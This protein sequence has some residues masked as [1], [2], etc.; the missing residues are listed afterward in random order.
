VSEDLP[1]AVMPRRDFIADVAALGSGSG[2]LPTGIEDFRTGD[3]DG[4]FVFQFCNETETIDLAAMIPEVSDYPHEHS[5]FIYTTSDSA[6]PAINTVLDDA[7]FGNLR[8]EAMLG[9]LSNLLIKTVNHDAMDLDNELDDL[10]F[11]EE[12]EEDA[13]FGDEDIY[14]DRV[15]QDET[16]QSHDC[17]VD[18]KAFITPVSLLTADEKTE[19]ARKITHDLKLAKD[20]GFRVSSLGNLFSG[21][22]CMVI[23]GCC[24]DALG[25][26]KDTQN[27]WHMKSGNYVLLVIRYPYGYV[28]LSEALGKSYSSV[29]LR[30]VMTSR[31]KMSLSQAIALFDSK[32]KGN[33]VKSSTD[34]SETETEI[35]PLF[36]DG[37]LNDFLNQRFLILVRHR[38]TLRVGWRGAEAYYLDSQGK[39]T[40]TIV[41]FDNKYYQEEDTPALPKIAIA[42]HLGE[43]RSSFS[44]PLAAIQL[45]LR[46]LVRCVEFCQI[47]HDRVNTSF[48]ALKPFVCDKPLCLY[49][50]MSLG[51]GPT[52]ENEIVR[53]PD[54]VD[55]LVSFCYRAAI[56]DQ[57]YGKLPVGV[58]MTV[59]PIT[60]DVENFLALQ[61][62][63]NP[64]AGLTIFWGQLDETR[65][66]IFDLKQKA[67][68]MSAKKSP[69][70]KPGQWIYV[71]GVG[72]RG[73]CLVR[74]SY[75]NNT[76]HVDPVLSLVHNANSITAD[77]SKSDKR[78]AKGVGIAVWNRQFA[79]MN[80]TDQQAAIVS[81]LAILPSV[82]DMRMY[83]LEN[84]QAP[85]V[86]G[87]WE[88]RMPPAVLTLL[89]WIVASNRSCIVQVDSLDGQEPPEAGLA[90]LPSNWLQFRFAQGAPDKEQRFVDEVKRSI[91]RNGSPYPTIFGWHGSPLGNWHNI[92]REG[93]HFK[94]VSHGRAMGHGVYHALDMSTS[95]CYARSN[96]TPFNHRA[97]T[98]RNFSWPGS[99]L[100]V[101]SAL[102]LNEIINAPREFKA[103]NGNVLVVQ[104]VDWIQTRYLVLECDELETK[105]KRLPT[106]AG[107]DQD[108]LLRAHR[109]ST[110]MTGPLRT[111][112][113]IP[114]KAIPPS[115]LAQFT[116]QPRRELGSL[117]SEDSDAESECS[118]TSDTALYTLSAHGI[119]ATSAG[120]TRHRPQATD[121]VP[122]SLDHSMLPLLASP[123]YA[124]P[125]ASKTLQRELRDLLAV[126]GKNDLA[127]LGWY[128]NANLVQNLYQWIVELHSFPPETELAK[129][130][131]KKGMTSVVLELRFGP[132][133]PYAPPFV[134][135]VRP[136]FVPFSAGGGGH[137]TM[138]GAMCMELLTNNGWNP[139]STI[140][141]VL[142]QVRVA[143]LNPN[144]V[145]ARLD[146]RNNS[147]M[148]YGIGEA[149]AAFRR[150]CEAHGWV[151]SEETMKVL[152]MEVP[153][154][155]RR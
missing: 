119:E 151:P 122:G 73:H 145:P 96:N 44:L 113:V 29:T 60:S 132:T 116:N 93:L 67:P 72:F 16:H 87:R 28:A 54:V 108:P 88:G 136:R 12:E 91:S 124:T 68:I 102:C 147:H 144:P 83:I 86:L 45:G 112:I 149:V 8:V 47:C 43:K 133:F 134:R 123:A 3:D 49:Q 138:G 62:Y 59:P 97:L 69:L 19:L 107:I 143:L 52:I 41:E 66:I 64:N 20:A 92:I 51:F 99:R 125:Q 80:E 130:L 2:S 13:D 118:T 135:V 155:P 100:G 11:Q 15:V 53:Q 150:A 103:N 31:F 56:S 140:E 32:E 89:R 85:G 109:T 142:L 9:R 105:I 77:E 25:I 18:E 46:H 26:T 84:G 17:T 22:A 40:R 104:Y 37:P 38:Q 110:A 63:D 81:L 101:K 98:G 71:T 94:K 154:G 58:Q 146:T 79:E 42:D 5:W 152:N 139:A 78:K 128:V 115:R 36:I 30:M 74:G 27:A 75:D 21:N 70:P 127:D 82:Q 141:A 153:A 55:L 131:K 129:D 121:F 6:S 50:Y 14:L 4:T 24:I 90:G 39:Y 117:G 35:E 48:E 76:L 7:D 114:I 34:E 95:V 57:L 148:D 126:Q 111:E 120:A 1:S 106:L 61:R 33:G 23:L 10:L 65:G 137:I